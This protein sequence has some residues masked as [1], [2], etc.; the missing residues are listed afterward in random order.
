MDIQIDAHH[1]DVPY[2]FGDTV[3]EAGSE[4][5]SGTRFPRRRPGASQMMETVG[6]G[7][8]ILSLFAPGADP[9]EEE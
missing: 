7:R 6:I 4:R 1:H 3:R 8:A 2:F 9:A 5:G